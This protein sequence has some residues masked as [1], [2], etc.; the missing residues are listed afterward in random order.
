MFCIEKTTGFMLL[1]LIQ[2]ERASYHTHTVLHVTTMTWKRN[3]READHQLIW[4]IG[5]CHSKL[6]IYLLCISLAK[7]VS[8]YMLIIWTFDY[9]I[10]K[11]LIVLICN[12]SMA[13]YQWLSKI[14]TLMKTDITYFWYI[15]F[16]VQAVIIWWSNKWWSFRIGKW[17]GG[18][19]IQQRSIGEICG[20]VHIHS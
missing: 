3:S 13:N 8:I 18:L 19:S 12:V 10:K 15:L 16:I 7:A 9:F 17:R 5:M 20:V 1:W 2:D 6:V 14:D 4:H 11:I